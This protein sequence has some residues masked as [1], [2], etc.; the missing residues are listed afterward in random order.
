MRKVRVWVLAAVLSGC[1]APD[2]PEGDCEEEGCPEGQHLDADGVTCVPEECGVGPWGNIDLEG[3][4]GPVIHVAPFGSAD[5]DGSVQRPLDSISSALAMAGSL[6][7][8]LVAV[9]AGTWEGFFP[10]SGELE[11]EGRC[12][13]LTMIDASD[14]ES[15]GYL[16]N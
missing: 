11:L 12:P 10:I 3:Y 9:A 2:C 13:A 14:R 8:P 7:A 5:G 4:G 1:V 15:G 6:E 16:L